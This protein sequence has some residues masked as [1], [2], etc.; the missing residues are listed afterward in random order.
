MKNEYQGINGHEKPERIFSSIELSKNLPRPRHMKTHLPFNLL[1]KQI[2]TGEKKPRIIFVHRN[3][4]DVCV[5]FYHFQN[6]HGLNND[7]EKHLEFF[8]NDSSKLKYFN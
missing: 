4:K 6:M 8:L 5:S 2:R 7:F 3:P 1:P